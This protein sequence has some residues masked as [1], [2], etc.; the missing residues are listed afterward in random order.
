MQPFLTAFYKFVVPTAILLPYLV[1]NMSD[2]A[3]LSLW[4][5]RQ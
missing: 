4:H 2:V 3:H 5:S 1:A